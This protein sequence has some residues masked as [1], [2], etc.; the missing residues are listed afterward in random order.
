MV[1]APVQIGTFLMYQDH[2]ESSANAS[3][4]PE[5]NRVELRLAYNFDLENRFR[6]DNTLGSRLKDPA[7]MQ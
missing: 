4:I 5:A 1:Q 2:R 6:P 3:C 7:S